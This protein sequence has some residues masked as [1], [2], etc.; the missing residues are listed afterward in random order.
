MSLNEC[1]HTE[2]RREDWGTPQWLFERL[3]G[4]FNFHID[5]AANRWNSKCAYSIEASDGDNGMLSDAPGVIREKYVDIAGHIL[6]G[7][8]WCNPPYGK[9]GCGKW[10]KEIFRV[11]NTVSL[12]PASVGSGWYLQCWREAS[13]I[14]QFHKRL[15]FEGAPSPA[16]FDSAI[17][18][19]GG[20]LTLDQLE[21]LSHIGTVVHRGGII[22]W[23]GVW[24]GP[25]RKRRAA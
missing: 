17:V 10:M 5:L 11:P 3:N 18:V 16:Q 15:R 21:Q 1:N 25:E 7:W 20:I 13:A 8:A 14:V 22:D 23:K 2:T 12:I 24:Y 6:D 4:I 9:S 19:K